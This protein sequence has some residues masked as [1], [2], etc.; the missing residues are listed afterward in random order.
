MFTDIF[1]LGTFIFGNGFESK[2]IHMQKKICKKNLK[3]KKEKKDIY[4]IQSQLF[5]EKKVK[6]S[7][8][9]MTYLDLP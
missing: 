5:N 6:N 9:Q 1:I 2:S 7:T 4:R 8:M 3:N